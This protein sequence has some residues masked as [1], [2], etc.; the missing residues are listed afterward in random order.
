MVPRCFV[1]YVTN[2]LIM[3]AIKK[4]P[5][6]RQGLSSF[7]N[8]ERDKRDARDRRDLKLEP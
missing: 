7:V 8:C 2:N 1:G 6:L 5:P 3:K 4:F